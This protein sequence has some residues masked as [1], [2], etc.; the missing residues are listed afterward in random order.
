MTVP[1]LQGRSA[2]TLAFVHFDQPADWRCACT[3]NGAP[4]PAMAT[5][6]GPNLVSTP[7]LE[8]VDALRAYAEEHSVLR[9]LSRVETRTRRAHHVDDRRAHVRLRPVQLERPVLA[10]LKPGPL[11]TLVDVSAGG[12]LIETPAR[13]TPGAQVLLEF[14]APGTRRAMVLRSRI[15]RSHVAAVDR[16]SMRYRGA[17]SFDGILQL[18]DLVRPGP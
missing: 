17:C 8:I 1:V 15:M 13:L 11:L 14:L 10:R 7:L 18:S 16:N 5:C 2:K 3:S 9:D 4:G 6:R 12:A